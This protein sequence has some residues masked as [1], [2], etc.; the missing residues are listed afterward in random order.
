MGH[1]WV[2]N[3]HKTLWTIYTT[4]GTV[5]ESDSEVYPEKQIDINHI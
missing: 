4:H 1:Q 3:L 2:C 5:M